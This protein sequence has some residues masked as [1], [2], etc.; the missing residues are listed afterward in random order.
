LA[1]WAVNRSLAPTSVNGISLALG[2]CAAAWFSA[3]TRPDNIRGAV[4]L[5]ASYL[6]WRAARWLAGP[7]PGAGAARPAKP[8]AGTLAE[9]SG[10]VSDYMVYAG[11]AVGGYEARWSGTW[12]LAAAVVI[13]TAVRGTAVAC[14]GHVE[15][16]SG[17]PNSPVSLLRGF[18]AFSTGGR[19]AVI[20]IA[21]PIWGAHATL[22][23]LLEWGIIATAYVITGHGP[24]RVAVADDA[25][26]FRMAGRAEAAGQPIRLGSFTRAQLPARQEPP[27]RTELSARAEFSACVDPPATA[28][29]PVRED[30]S[31]A[32]DAS[33]MENSVVPLTSADRAVF[34]D[35]PARADRAAFADS[36]VPA[37]RAAFADSPA[38]ESPASADQAGALDSPGLAD[39]VVPADAPAPGD[40]R[41]GADPPARA[42]G[43]GPVDSLT[44]LGSAGLSTS[45]ALTR[46]ASGAGQSETPLALASSSETT[47]T[48]ELMIH[49]EP[50]PG[51]EPKPKTVLEPDALATIAAY[52]DDGAVAVWLS[53]VVRGQ[54][55]PLPPAV[56]GLAATSFLAWLGMRNLGGLLLLT[57]LVVMLLAAF[58]SGHPHNG[59]LDWLVPALLVA[60]QLV[61]IAAIGFSFGVWAPVTFMLCALIAL[62]YVDL[63]RPGRRNAPGGA[64]TKLGWEGRMLAVGIGAMLG[65]TTVAFVALS[66]Y[67]AALVC[68]RVRT[69]ILAVEAADRP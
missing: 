68:G 41:P 49:I 60:G 33:V 10:T 32:A 44:R 9:L 39:P 58:G 24:E 53:R 67:V 34:P 23:I 46:L 56:A 47:M 21:A 15:G 42:L 59:R 36:P 1:D 5:F 13:A 55:V 11:L 16:G 62:R 4:A 38:P 57:P 61:Y 69:S 66:V 52:R 63:A 43:P 2:L 6:A 50:D 45:A 35:S 64:A 27:T 8:G 7:V 37:D 51:P 48:L 65:I 54:F 25:G 40:S 28:G 22:L 3:G 14:G 26:R 12:V 18:L 30:S 31:A 17:E 19:V 20:A 29:S